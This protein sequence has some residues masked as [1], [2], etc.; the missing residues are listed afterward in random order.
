MLL[1]D[2]HNFLFFAI[3]ENLWKTTCR[4]CMLMLHFKTQ[5]INFYMVQVFLSVFS[6]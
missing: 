1:I 6:N 3:I 4:K 5:T 2:K